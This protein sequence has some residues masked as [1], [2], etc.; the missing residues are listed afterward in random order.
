MMMMTIAHACN[1]YEDEF[2]ALEVQDRI[3]FKS[4][5]PL[6]TRYLVSIANLVIYQNF[7]P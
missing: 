2:G 4:R 3:L 5:L 1:S 7:S 6:I